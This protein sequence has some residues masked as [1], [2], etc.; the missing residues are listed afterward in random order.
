MPDEF[1]QNPQAS[2]ASLDTKLYGSFDVP[3]R[4]RDAWRADNVSYAQQQETLRVIKHTDLM[5]YRYQL[6][7]FMLRPNY[8]MRKK[9]AEYNATQDLGLDGR[10]CLAMH[11]R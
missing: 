10:K 5:W 7:R 8:M 4:Y 9:I 3:I 11:V 2:R 6:I 1:Y